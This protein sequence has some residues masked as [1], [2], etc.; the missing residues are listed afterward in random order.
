MGVSAQATAV[1]DLTGSV[2]DGFGDPVPNAVVSL[3]RGGSAT[4]REVVTGRNGTFTF[5]G[6]P[7]GRYDVRAEALGFHP[8]V[9]RGIAVRPGSGADVPLRLRAGTPPVTVVDTMAAPQGGPEA[10]RWLE[11]LEFDAPADARTL[12][13]VLGVVPALDRE[14]GALGLPSGYTTVTV[15]GVPFR[16]AT[17]SPGRQDPATLLTAGSMGLVRVAPLG[18][19]GALGLGA[20]GEVE[21][22]NPYLRSGESEL[23]AAAS[24]EPLWAGRFETGEGLTPSS[25][26]LQ[27]RTALDLV[28]DSVRVVVG[29]DFHHVE[30]PRPPLFT[31][32]AGPT[33]P[34][35]EDSD[36]VSAFALLDW[37]L[38][39]GSRFDFGARVGS[40]PAVKSPFPLSWPGQHSG[41]EAQD[42]TVGTGLVTGVAEQ[43]TLSIRGGFTRSARSGG[44]ESWPLDPSSPLLVDVA[45]GDRAGVAPQAR[46]EALRQGIFGSVGV[47]LDAA[48]HSLSAGLEVLRSSHELDPLAG[49]SLW[50]GAGD[51]F[52]S[53]WVGA[54][55]RYENS[56]GARDFAGTHFAFSVRDVWR[57]N[58]NVQLELA[59]R[60]HQESLPVEDL[61]PSAAWYSLTGIVPGEPEATA[62]GI[63]GHLGL[64][65][66]AGNGAVRVTA[67]AGATVDETDPWLFAEA[68]A[69]DGETDHLRVLVDGS[70][71]E[72]W[73]AFPDPADGR[74]APSLLL[75]PESRDLPATVYA[76]G[77]ISTRQA[78]LTFGVSGI[79][80]RTENLARRVDLNR[81]SVPSGTTEAG[82][83]VWGMPALQGNL[84]TEVP[85]S[86]RRFQ[87]FDHV[88][89]VL[90][91]GWSQ[92]LG[93]TVS[94]ERRED[95][96][97]QLGA[98][99][100]LSRTTD[101]LP[102]LWAGRP[103]L[104]GT[105]AVP[106]DEDWSEGTSDL[107]VPHR[108]GAVLALPFP[109]LEGGVL[110]SRLQLIS[111]RAFTPGF[112]SGVDLNA[113]GIAG[114]DPVFIPGDGVDGLPDR[115]DCVTDSRGAWLERNSCR[116]PWIPYL[117]VGLSL[118]LVRLGGANLSLQVDAFNLLQAYDTT[119]D[120]ALFLVDPSGGLQTDGT[121]QLPSLRTNTGLGG[122]LFDSRP[123]RMIRFG[124]RWG[125]GR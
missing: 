121:A 40:R 105:T 61:N 84:L 88:W 68:L 50:I 8:M 56:L 53:G 28:P 77:G 57:P 13:E 11:E 125:G 122:E 18:P 70:G 45:S 106:G 120:D 69:L 15:Q 119:V 23:F 80:R 79:F 66:L 72:P 103:E 41:L 109:L 86:S 6:L 113:D 75:F 52:T 89:A 82:R 37:D 95:D 22:F 46:G 43:A 94:V 107:D 78:G 108:L 48:D 10:Q 2:A 42:V 9:V 85:G 93:V 67:A 24:F 32:G 30:R 123:G 114:N 87:D 29:A 55:A 44:E 117:D 1:S 60:W 47:G 27:G 101:N 74:A 36:V 17:V 58:A 34:G 25:L 83:P 12:R 4:G 73:P 96:G 14:M 100:T 38:G 76:S 5:P 92:Y 115:W 3:W 90:Q 63:G 35:L 16:S 26:W 110:R 7:P 64:D 31:Q 51:G 118:A 99:Y 104:A 49:S 111:G 65:W 20:G 112:R 21:V 19:S 91:D 81:T 98:W 62:T 71:S 54:A 124:L 33:G 116:L 97:V 39:G 102:G 59:G